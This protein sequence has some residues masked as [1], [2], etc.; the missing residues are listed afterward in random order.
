[1]SDAGAGREYEALREFLVEEIGDG[2]RAIDRFDRTT[3]EH[4][5]LRPDVSE[6]Y[7]DQD[8]ER[9]RIERVMNA[10]SSESLEQLYEVG[11]FR[12]SVRRFDD[13]LLFYLL[14]EDAA[15]VVVSI[16]EEVDVSLPAFGDR[17]LE[18]AREG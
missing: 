14:V 13:A 11:S 8:F 12:Y 9:L 6:L 10:V 1:M 18:L 15:G 16:D 7:T 17:C 2:L 3:Y 5:Y 4:V